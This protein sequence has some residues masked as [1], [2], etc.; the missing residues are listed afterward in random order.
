MISLAAITTFGLLAKNA[1][2][3]VVDKSGSKRIERRGEKADIYI[4]LTTEDLLD[5]NR[6]VYSL[7]RAEGFKL[8]GRTHY[9][10]L[11]RSFLSPNVCESVSDDT[12]VIEL[13]RIF[14][15]IME[16]LMFPFKKIGPLPGKRPTSF[17]AEGQ[18]V[19]V[20]CRSEKP[21]HWSPATI[22]KVATTESNMGTHGPFIWLV[23][24]LGVNPGAGGAIRFDSG[25][26]WPRE[27]D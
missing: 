4:K 25:N 18:K 3:V 2:F 1:Y 6:Q 24:D 14:F 21:I 13:S 9:A 16:Q 15:S 11:V 7:E 20:V 17:F 22:A 5:R 8:D 19:W 12:P 23:E 26:I 10:V 27:D